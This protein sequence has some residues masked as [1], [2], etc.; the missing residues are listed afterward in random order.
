M[1]KSSYLDSSSYLDVCAVVIFFS[2]KLMSIEDDFINFEIYQRSF[3]F[4]DAYIQK[5]NVCIYS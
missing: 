4:E 3:K 5:L 1:V 2:P